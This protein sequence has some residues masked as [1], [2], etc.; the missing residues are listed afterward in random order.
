MLRRL[1]CSPGPL[2]RRRFLTWLTASIS[3]HAAFPETYQRTERVPSKK[4]LACSQKLCEHRC[5]YQSAGNQYKTSW[6]VYQDTRFRIWHSW[7]VLL[8]QNAQLAR[9]VVSGAN[10]SPSPLR[11]CLHWL[12]RR[13]KVL[14][15]FYKYANIAVTF[16]RICVRI[17]GDYYED[18]QASKKF[19]LFVLKVAERDA[20]KRTLQDST[21]STQTFEVVQKSKRRSRVAVV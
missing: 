21:G 13:P 5:R 10:L 20:L 19:T 7:G 11:K 17:F 1:I 4:T 16:S 6:W 18:E 15:Y 8:L 14:G 3:V 9:M 2:S 12:F